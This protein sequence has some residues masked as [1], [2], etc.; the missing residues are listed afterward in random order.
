MSGCGVLGLDV[1][2]WGFEMMLCF[3]GGDG[4]W[5]GFEGGLRGNGV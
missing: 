4:G 1:G 3:G 2:D 5:R